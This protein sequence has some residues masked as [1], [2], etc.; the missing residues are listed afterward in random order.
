MVK[1]R[2][3]D[4]RWHILIYHSEWAEFLYYWE[5]KYFLI[6]DLDLDNYIIFFFILVCHRHRDKT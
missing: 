1:I 2:H 3:F 4:K 5:S 6:G